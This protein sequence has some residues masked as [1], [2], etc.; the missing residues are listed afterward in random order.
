MKSKHNTIEPPLAPSIFESENLAALEGYFK[1]LAPGDPSTRAVEPDKERAPMVMSF[2][3]HRE[4]PIQWDKLISEIPVDQTADAF[5][6]RR[7]LEDSWGFQP[8]L[9]PTLSDFVFQADAAKSFSVP[10][11]D[12]IE[13]FQKGAQLA[14]GEVVV[15]NCRTGAY[16]HLVPKPGAGIDLLSGKEAYE[17][18][19]RE[20]VEWVVEVFPM[21]KEAPCDAMAD[22]TRVFGRRGKLAQVLRRQAGGIEPMF[23]LSEEHADAGKAKSRASRA[24]K[25]GKGRDAGSLQRQGDRSDSQR[26]R[27]LLGRRSPREAPPDQPCS[28]GLSSQG[29]DGRPRK[30]TSPPLRQGDPFRPCDR[31]L[32]NGTARG[33][34]DCAGMGQWRTVLRGHSQERGR[35]R[36][37]LRPAQ[38]RTHLEES[39]RAPGAGHESPRQRRHRPVSAFR[40]RRRDRPVPSRH[41]G[42]VRR[43]RR[44]Q[45]IFKDF[46]RQGRR[47]SRRH[48]RQPR[49][50]KG[51][52]GDDRQ[53]PQS[54]TAL[55]G[56]RT[57][58][59]TPSEPSRP[60]GLFSRHRRRHRLRAGPG[61]ER[62]QSQRQKRRTL[63][64]GQKD[65][66]LGGIGPDASGREEEFP[67]LRLDPQ[68]VCRPAIPA[69]KRIH[70]LPKSIHGPGAVGGKTKKTYG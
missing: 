7:A 53:V 30:E 41:R 28:L 59:K 43:T 70:R 58:Q 54:Q 34:R 17:A 5:F 18:S 6:L 13:A 23:R 37:S 44:L 3:R 36:L 25:N 42:R 47:H 10:P 66:D 45:R 39:N 49:E 32:E 21:F 64:G 12:K 1:V 2:D 26:N 20:G 24:G 19:W 56:H 38:L 63:P 51:H 33:R 8:H 60:A 67:F 16:Y 46:E 22:T 40:P 29:E 31:P 11:C 27:R 57:G 62:V 68:P 69:T 4:L 48:R 35:P 55:Q 15:R 61:S 52:R 65:R 9:E 50:R 14:S